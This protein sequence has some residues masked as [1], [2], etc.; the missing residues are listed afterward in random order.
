MLFEHYSKNKKVLLL[1]SVTIL[2]L[3]IFTF[4]S[5]PVI[6]QEGNPWPQIKGISQ[7]TF[8][9]ADIVKLSD[10]DNRYLTR[11]QNG[12]MVIEVFMKDRGYEY[13]DQMGS[14]YFYKSSDSTIVL[15]RR[16][17]SRFYVIWTITEN[18]NDADNN[19][20]TTTTNDEGVTYQYPKELLAKYISVVDWPPIVKIETGTYSC[21]TTPQEMGSISDITSQRLVDDRTYCV[22]VKH[23]GAAGSVYSSYTYTTTKSDDLVKVSFTLQYPN[24]IN[25]DEAQSKT[26]INERETFDLDSTIDRIVQTIK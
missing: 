2:M 6:F 10:S 15:T 9:G 18:S 24:C 20:W 5:S 14:G 13:T 11:N 12:P 3:G 23:E 1:V 26:C 22:N 17:Y 8:G 19:L 16:Q 7:L 25:Y 4:F 21:K